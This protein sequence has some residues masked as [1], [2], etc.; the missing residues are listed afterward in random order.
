MFL[1][2]CCLVIVYVPYLAG[3]WGLFHVLYVALVLSKVC[4]RNSRLA[5]PRKET[6]DAY[7]VPARLDTNRIAIAKKVD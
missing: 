5:V 6:G 3:F 4:S 7:R 1:I 2:Y